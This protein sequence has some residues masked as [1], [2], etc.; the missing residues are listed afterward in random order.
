MKKLIIIVIYLCCWGI[1]AQEKIIKVYSTKAGRDTSHKLIYPEMINVIIL[2]SLAAST[3]KFYIKVNDSCVISLYQ[4]RSPKLNEGEI[5][6]FNEYISQ[7][8]FEYNEN[9]V[10]IKDCSKYSSLFFPIKITLN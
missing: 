3:Y 1:S 7:Y 6:I 8:T 9:E 10:L 5:A 2:K 4:E